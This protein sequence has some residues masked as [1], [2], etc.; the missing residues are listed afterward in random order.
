MLR[1]EHIQQEGKSIMTNVTKNIVVA[2]DG[3]EQSSHAAKMA[4][5]LA[6]ATGHPLKLLTVFPGSKAERLI[7]SG[8]WPSDLEEEQKN[9][10]R[11]VFDAAKEAVSGI[12]DPS[13]EILLKGDPAH[14]IIEYL[15]EHPGS[16][17]VL[18]RR[19][20]S[21]L[22]SLTLGSISERVVRHATGPVTVVSE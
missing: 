7:I 18:G 16:H 3:S 5:D 9:Y 19:G 11:K 4:A 6:K 20:H 15:Q 13:E 2:C 8:V 22:R 10:G 1:W 17:M 12:A 14:E 21:T